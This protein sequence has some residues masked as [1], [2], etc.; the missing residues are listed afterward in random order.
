MNP[1]RRQIRKSLFAAFR[2]NFKVE[3]RKDSASGFL[4]DATSYKRRSPRGNVLEKK[5]RYF[6]AYG[7]TKDAALAGL[8]A[9]IEGL[10]RAR[11]DRYKTALNTILH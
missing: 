6:F 7:K 5:S 4:A 3:V 1:L 8:A 2:V 10:F 9:A 11:L